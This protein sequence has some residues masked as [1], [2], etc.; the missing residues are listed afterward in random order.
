MSRLCCWPP[1]TPWRWT[2]PYVRYTGNCPLRR[3]RRCL[4]IAVDETST[5]LHAAAIDVANKLPTVSVRT[6]APGLDLKGRRR[7]FA[8]SPADV[9]AFVRTSDDKDLGQLLAPALRIPAMYPMGNLGPRLFSRRHALG[10]LG[11]VSITALVAA[12]SSSTSSADT[13]VATDSTSVSAATEPA[14]VP[15]SGPDS[16]PTTLAT[17]T[18]AK[19]ELASEMTEGP[20]YLDLNMVRADIVE[21]RKGAALALSLVVLDAAT[22]SPIEGAVV[23]IWHCDADG[24]YSGFQSASAGSNGGGGGGGGGGGQPPPDGGGIGGLLPTDTG[25]A[26]GGGGGGGGATDTATF[27]RGTQLSDAA[28]AV[29]FNSIYPCWYAGRT[30]HIHV[31]VHVKGAVIHTGQVFFDDAFTDTV[32]AANAPY[33]SR[34]A[35]DIRNDGDGIYGQGGSTSVLSVIKAGSGYTSTLNVGV[36]SS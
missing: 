2:L 20:Y 25:G 33:S 21:D 29:T 27:L 26:A 34:S 6:L 9:V 18:A 17:A 7:A 28:G 10:L 36:K 30:V 15:D 12:C 23:D 22:A 4:T 11:G 24:V 1:V 8:S 32:Y 31:K 13:T 5:Q 19:V 16:A 35:R 14:S 3:P